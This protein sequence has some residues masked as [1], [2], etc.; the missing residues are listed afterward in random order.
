MRGQVTLETLILLSGLFAFAAALWMASLPLQE[1]AM[2]RAA[3]ASDEASF[4]P[5]RFAVRYAAVSAPGFS[6]QQD[7]TLG[8]NATLAWT[9]DA[10]HWR[11]VDFNHTLAAPFGSSGSFD[12][13][14]GRHVLAV[15]RTLQ[16]IDL[17]VD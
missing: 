11:S 17:E 12:L 6:L 7:W 13:S 1:A 3:H 16:G 9:E 14:E 2:G 10:L 15:R 4:E 8:R 5:L